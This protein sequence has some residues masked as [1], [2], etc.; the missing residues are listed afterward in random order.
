MG[1]VVGAAGCLRAGAALRGAG[2]SWLAGTGRAEREGTD[3]AGR[4]LRHGVGTEPLF[5]ALQ[6]CGG[7]SRRRFC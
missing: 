7:E 6:C 2:M 4:A 3:G 5:D 1:G